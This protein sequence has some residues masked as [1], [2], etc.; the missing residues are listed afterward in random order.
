MWEL[1]ITRRTNLNGKIVLYR[2]YVKNVN[3]VA[4]FKYV[5]TAL[6]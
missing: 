4:K 2:E 5:S 1:I 6:N 3:G